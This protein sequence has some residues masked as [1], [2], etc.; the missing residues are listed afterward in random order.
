MITEFKTVLSS[1]LVSPELQ[2]VAVY[3]LQVFCLSQGY[4][5]PLVCGLL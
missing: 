1:Y 3:Q 4:A 2:L 5:P